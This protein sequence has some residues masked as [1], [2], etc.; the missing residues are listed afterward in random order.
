MTFKV[1]LQAM[2]RAHRIGQTKPV[3]VF[4]FISEGT[5]EE[6][7]IERADRKLFLDAAVI[8]QGRLAEQNSSLDKGDLMKMVRFGADQIVSS[9]GGTYTDEDIDA[10]I[11]RGEERTSA[12]QAKLE[13]NAQ[14]SLANFTLLAEDETTTD[15]FEFGGVNYRDKG[16]VGNFINLPQRQRKRNYDLGEADNSGTIVVKKMDPSS[17]K[18]RKGPV[19]YDFQLFDMKRLNELHKREDDLASKKGADHNLIATLRQEAAQAPIHGSGVAAGRSKEE[20]LSRVVQLERQL[21]QYEFTDAEKEERDDI[22]AEGFPDWSRKDFKAF[23]TSLERHGRYDFSNVC[24]EVVLETGKDQAEIARYFVAF[25]M[26]Y[27]RILEWA[28][29]I[30]KI[31]RGEKK[32]QRLRQIR[33]VIHEK[34]ERHLED[35]FGHLFG[36]DGTVDKNQPLPSMAE[37]LH[38]SWPKMKINYGSSSRGKGYQEDEDSFLVCMMYRHGYGAA[39][40]IRMEIR[41]AWQFRFDWYFKSRSALDIQKR[42]DLLV[43]IVEREI[44]DLHKKEEAV[45]EEKESVKEQ[46]ALALERLE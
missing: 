36:P 27:Q 32:I 1:D 39:E 25:W 12:I 5:V 26:N 19:L 31:E 41:R 10:L 29:I 17:K 38:Y 40:R 22:Y 18:K 4:R 20:L 33:E 24:Q 16:T 46:S 23:C 9:K 21:S 14:H 42:C 11:A 45:K 44:E 15:T 43:R 3:S 6:K 37:L 7:I 13:T 35:T 34:V 28:K 8:Q 30:E 2:D